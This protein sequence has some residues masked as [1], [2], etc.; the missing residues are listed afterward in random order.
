MPPVKPYP[1]L[2]HCANPKCGRMIGVENEDSRRIVSLWVLVHSRQATTTLEELELTIADFRT[3]AMGHG[4][5]VCQCG[6][7]TQWY[8]NQRLLERL[9]TDRYKRQPK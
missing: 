5:V 6:H 4:G 7:V 9:I 2:F 1:R 8:A 3:T